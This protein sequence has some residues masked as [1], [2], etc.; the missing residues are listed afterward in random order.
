MSVII[1]YEFLLL[2]PFKG[3]FL[4]FQV[5]KMPGIKTKMPHHHRRRKTQNF[6]LILFI[7]KVSKLSR[8]KVKKVK[9]SKT[10]IARVKE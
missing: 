2:L 5:W 1:I 10:F 6:F 3:F 9:S 7:K 8:G 4:N